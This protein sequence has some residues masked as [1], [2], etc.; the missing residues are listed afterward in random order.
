MTLQKII[1]KTYLFPILL[2][3][4]ICL[5]CGCGLYY[6]YEDTSST[7]RTGGESDGTSGGIRVKEVVDGDTIILSDGSRLRLIGINTPEHGM[8]FF[9]EA[10]EVLEAIVLDREVVL[11][12]DISDTDKYGRLLRY[13]YSGDLFV[14]LEMVKR[15]FANAY[16][17][18]PD[19]KYTEKFLEA[20]RYARENNLGLW[21]KSKVGMVKIEINYDA[22]GNDNMNLNDEY[23]L[24]KNSGADSIDIDSWTVKDSATNI[25]RFKKYLFESGS[26]VY[27]FTGSGNDGEGKFYWDSPQP[28]WNNDSDTLYLRDREGLLVEIYNY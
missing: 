15:G 27:L 13:V 20:E 23:V 18:P 24:I 16:T 5:L 19:V 22:P 9:E 1:N 2:I 17:F 6:D 3:I 26:T 28:I 21:L 8:Y 7:S 11:E 14:N 12:K 25:Y 4:F 10:R